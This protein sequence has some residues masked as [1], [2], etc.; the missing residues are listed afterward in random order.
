MIVRLT[1]D[2][3]YEKIGEKGKGY[4]LDEGVK[5]RAALKKRA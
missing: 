1:V 5:L 2:E 4:T 3:C